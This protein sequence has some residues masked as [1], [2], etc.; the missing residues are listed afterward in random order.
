MLL[1]VTD[2]QICL[3]IIAPGHPSTSQ[4][5]K[6]DHMTPSAN[7]RPCIH[8]NPPQYPS[9]VP[10]SSS[11]Q[12]GHPSQALLRRGPR[13]CPLGT[14]LTSARLLG[15]G[16]PPRLQDA[17]RGPRLLRV[18]PSLRTLEGVPGSL[19]TNLTYLRCGISP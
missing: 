4:V 8:A 3:K 13:P 1:K 9:W 19:L 10:L 5:L 18:V 6:H 14:P 11:L 17:R 7:Q 16:T 15:L 12:R 2:L